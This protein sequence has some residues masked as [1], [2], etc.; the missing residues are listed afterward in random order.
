[1][2]HATAM[3]KAAP[4]Q[5][6]RVVRLMNPSATPATIDANASGIGLPKWI[7]AYGTTDTNTAPVPNRCLVPWTRNPRKK[8]SSPT[9]CAA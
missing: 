4:S 8:N 5:I 3:C 1:M 9:N 7:I 6:D 2:L